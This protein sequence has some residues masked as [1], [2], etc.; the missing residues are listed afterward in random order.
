[1]ALL[2]F[3]W[4]IW[5]DLIP[6]E[7]LSRIRLFTRELALQHLCSLHRLQINACF[8]CES[9]N[10][11]WQHSSNKCEQSQSRSQSSAWGI[12]C[13]QAF[14][15][16]GCISIGSIPSVKK[17][18]QSVCHVNSISTYWVNL[19]NIKMIK[20]HFEANG[21]SVIDFTLSTAFASTTENFTFTF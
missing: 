18:S 4:G 14:Q 19:T 2:H 16:K 5:S 8:V 20:A 9:W 6:I 7:N 15:C 11:H 13:Y 3:V 10:D 1:M 21:F 12:E 17:L